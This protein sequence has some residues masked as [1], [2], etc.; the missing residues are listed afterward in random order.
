MTQT[1]PNPTQHAQAIYSL[2][3]QIAALLGEAL[4][5]DFT[6]SGTALGQSEVVDQAL[7]GQ[8]QYGLLACALDKIEI[9]Q[10]TSPGYWA[11]LHQELKRLI[12]REAHA[13]AAE[14]LRPLT[15]VVSDQEMAA[16]SEAIYNPLGPYEECSLARLQ[17]GLNG[18]P[19]EVLAARVVK[20]FFAKGEEPSAIADRVINLALEGSHTL[21]LKGGLA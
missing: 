6:F 5:R 1:E 15:A 14:I 20:S 3:A 17:E 2:S 12:A 11:K 9:N 7:D 10:A 13:S 19:F 8:M 21:F 16:I 4:R 18:T